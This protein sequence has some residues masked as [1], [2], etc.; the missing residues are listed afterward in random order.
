MF[1]NL[2]FSKV[3]RRFSSGFEEINS[4]MHAQSGKQFIV[5]VF[6]NQRSREVR[7]ICFEVKSEFDMH[8]ITYISCFKV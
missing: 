3:I 7:M 8:K 4:F 1:S 6:F 2:A 5:V